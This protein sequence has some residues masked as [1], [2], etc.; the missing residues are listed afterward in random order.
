[1]SI[2]TYTTG[3]SG[4]G[5]GVPGNQHCGMPPQNSAQSGQTMPLNANR[6]GSNWTNSTEGYGSMR[7]EQSMMSSRR[8]SDVSTRAMMN[9]PWDPMSADS[10]RRS[11]ACSNHGTGM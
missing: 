9:S 6:R 2:G 1:M 3:V 7:S 4:G 11:S 5:G 10:S 8:C